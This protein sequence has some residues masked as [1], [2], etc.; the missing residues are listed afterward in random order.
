MTMPMNLVLVRHGESEGNLATKLSKKGDDSMFTKA[1]MKRHSST[2]RLTE[3]GKSQAHVAGEWIKNTIGDS[4][5]RC[6]VSENDRATE[7]AALLDLPDARWM[8]THYLRERDWGA[9]DVL[10][11]KERR[12]TFAENLRR[13]EMDPFYW[14]PTGGESISTLCLRLEKILDTL[15]RK[16]GGKDAML[17]AHGEVIWGFRYILERMT[18]SEVR[19]LEQSDDPYDRIYNGQVIH[20]TRVDPVTGEVRPYLSWVRSICP[21][22]LTRS[23]NGW[24]EIQW[25]KFSNAELLREVELRHNT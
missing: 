24:K 8:V 23:N 19:R 11:F 4:F 17:V 22:N 7:T 3:K 1:F 13:K 15:H 2:W 20:Y 12:K 5:E 6:Y 25:K 21:D 10:P 18:N 16:C 9:L 14:T